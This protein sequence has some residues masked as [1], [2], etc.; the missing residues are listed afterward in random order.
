MGPSSR[1]PLRAATGTGSLGLDEGDDEQVTGDMVAT[2]FGPAALPFGTAGLGSTAQGYDTRWQ[3]DLPDAPAGLPRSVQ[4]SAVAISNPHAVQ[5]VD[6]VDSAPVAAIG[7]LVE[8]HPRFARRVNDGFM[9]DRKSAVEGK[10]VSVRVDH[11]GRGI[12]KKKI[13]QE[14]QTGNLRR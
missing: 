14:H 13:Q 11:G 7:P 8:R 10:S 3:L 9:Q 4:V 5:Q 1:I 6:D 12:M 2:R